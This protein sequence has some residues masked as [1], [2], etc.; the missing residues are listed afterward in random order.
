MICVVVTCFTK[1]AVL[2]IF[3][4]SLWFAAGRAVTVVLSVKTLPIAKTVIQ[5]T[6]IDYLQK[7]ISA[8]VFHKLVEDFHDRCA[9]PTAQRTLAIPPLDRF[10]TTTAYAQV[11]ARKERALLPRFLADHALLALIFV[12]KLH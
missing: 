5:E 8:P 3:S 9:H 1:R 10:C 6:T 11:P 7:L 4:S 2:L 12:V